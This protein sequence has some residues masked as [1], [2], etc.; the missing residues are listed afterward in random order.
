MT[1]RKPIPI[2]GLKMLRLSQEIQKVDIAS[3][4]FHHFSHPVRLRIMYA[5]TIEQELIVTETAGL[6]RSSAATASHHL[7]KM[8]EVNIL[9]K[10]KQGRENHYRIK[11]KHLE[12]VVSKIIA[13]KEQG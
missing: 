13:W 6:I 7:R 5:L 12:H 10:R 11:D 1:Y 8:H 2:H 3:P 9:E 4:I